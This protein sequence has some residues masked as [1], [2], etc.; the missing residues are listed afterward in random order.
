MMRVLEKIL[1]VNK[2]GVLFTDFIGPPFEYYY[3]R[4]TLRK[5]GI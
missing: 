3:K 5:N 1:T 2:S 4:Y